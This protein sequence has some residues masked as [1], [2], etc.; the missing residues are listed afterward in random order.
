[1]GMKYIFLAFF[2]VSGSLTHWTIDKSLSRQNLRLFSIFFIFYIFD[3]FYVKK[4]FLLILAHGLKIRISKKC[5]IKFK[6]TDG[7]NEWDMSQIAATIFL[8]MGPLCISAFF[9]VKFCNFSDMAHGKEIILH[10][11]YFRIFLSACIP[12]ICP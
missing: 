5:A 3:R 11:K 2:Y 8:E 4:R 9:E 10:Q 6:L 1:M 7:T 12:H